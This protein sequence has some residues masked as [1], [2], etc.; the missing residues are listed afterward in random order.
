[1]ISKKAAKTIAVLAGF[2]CFICTA[3]AEEQP[4]PKITILKAE[5]RISDGKPKIEVAGE[6]DL[7]EGAVLSIS[8]RK[9]A[10]LT[11]YKETKVASG[12]FDIVLG[13]LDKQLDGEYSVQVMFGLEQ[14]AKEVIDILKGSTPDRTLK[15]IQA[16]T[17]FKAA[18]TSG[19]TSPYGI[20]LWTANEQ[21][22]KRIILHV[23]GKTR[24]PDGAVLKVFLKR[25]DK[26]IVFGESVVSGGSFSISFG[27]SDNELALGTYTV[28]AEFFPDAQRSEFQKALNKDKIP[29]TRGICSAVIGKESDAAKAE[30]NARQVVSST[31]SSLEELYWELKDV[32]AMSLNHFDSATWDEW[33]DRWRFRLKKISNSLKDDSNGDKALLLYPEAG[34]GIPIAVKYL[35]D[36]YVIMTNTLK[37]RVSA[38]KGE[39]ERRCYALEAELIKLIEKMKAE[40]ASSPKGV[41]G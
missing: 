27:Q 30:N 3:R 17:L 41:D 19:E 24:L 6:T 26:I 28:E 20:E 22:G 35:S 21:Y 7:P 12:K 25:I 9:A 13:P 18:K 15:T 16:V 11:A 2:F 29:A 8:V 23:D 38:K 10:E 37:N 32:Y 5:Y 1:M 14:Q 4:S 36:I 33:S 34:K 39:L 31:V 40:L